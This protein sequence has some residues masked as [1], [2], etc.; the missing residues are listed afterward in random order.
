M[1]NFWSHEINICG[2]GFRILYKLGTLILSYVWEA[3]IDC[4][5]RVQEMQLS[6]LRFKSQ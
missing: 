6:C 3:A 2:S 4:V 1:E 5:V